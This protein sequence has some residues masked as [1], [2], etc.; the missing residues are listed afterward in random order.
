[1]KLDVYRSCSRAEKREVLNVYWHRGVETSSRIALAARQY[2]PWA[3]L[4]LIVLAVELVPVIALSFG[5]ANVVGVI[6]VAL[7]AVVLLSLYWAV[8]RYQALRAAPA[9]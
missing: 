9:T 1:M 4:C 3:I 6:A 2:G 8:V 5:H 7:E